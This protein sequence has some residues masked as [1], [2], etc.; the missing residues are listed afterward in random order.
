VSTLRAPARG[1]YDRDASA[2]DRFRSQ[3]DRVIWAVA[4]AELEG[5]ETVQRVVELAGIGRSTF[6]ECFDDYEHALHAVRQ[7]ESARLAVAC[8]AACGEPPIASLAA[9]WCS[10]VAADPELFL[11]ALRV[12]AST[13]SDSLGSVFSSALRA[14]VASDEVS[15]RDLSA[16]VAACA[17]SCARSLA[18]AIRATDAADAA[19]QL[20][21]SVAANLNQALE[22]LSREPAAVGN[23]VEKL[24]PTR[25]S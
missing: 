5:S 21:S 18:L 4:R 23:S 9:A 24:R 11:V 17:A 12:D 8:E 15:F 22:R 16:M 3:R 13:D 14:R 20:V 7:V 1:R 10:S 2:I 25:D 19:A 6:Y